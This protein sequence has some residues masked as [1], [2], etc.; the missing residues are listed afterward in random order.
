LTIEALARPRGHQHLLGGAGNAAPGDL[1]DD[2]LADAAETLRPVRVVECQIGTVAAQYRRGRRSQFRG[3]HMLGIVVAAD[4]IVFRKAGPARRRRRQ[5]V[6]E[7]MAVGETGG[8]HD[9]FPS[10]QPAPQAPW[11]DLV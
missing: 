4:E 5:V 9:V 1:G 8:G 6:G 10:Y 11:P 3:R 2:E 7:Q